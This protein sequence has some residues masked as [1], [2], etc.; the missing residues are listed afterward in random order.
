MNV[1]DIGDVAKRSGVLPSALRFYE[2]IGLIRS[3][4]RHGMRR[5]FEPSVLLK[6]SLI[7]LG[8]TAGFSLAD[9][10]RMFG[11][12]DT[13]CLPRAE[14][15]A[16]ADEIQRQML[17]LRMLRDALRHVADCPAPNHLECSSFRKLMRSVSRTRKSEQSVSKEARKSRKPPRR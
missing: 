16:K 15:H 2:E 4:G 11:T 10:A 9:I 12:D 14:L 6:L 8:R 3:V 17:E 7:G 5:Q 1:M 13:L